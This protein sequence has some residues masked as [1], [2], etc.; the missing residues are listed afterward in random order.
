M[1]QR[2][3]IGCRVHENFWRFPA[4]GHHSLNETVETDDETIRAIYVTYGARLRKR[5]RKAHV[6]EADID[7]V[8]HDLIVSL[9][10]TLQTGGP[11][12]AALMTYLYGVARNHI[13]NYFRRARGRARTVS[14]ASSTEDGEEDLVLTATPEERL[15]EEEFQRFF[16]ARLAQMKPERRD[17]LQLRFIDELP[18]DAV[19]EALRIPER[20]AMR[21]YEAALREVRVA[22]A[23]WARERGHLRAFPF[24]LILARLLTE[25]HPGGDGALHGD[26][27]AH[28]GHPPSGLDDAAHGRGSRTLDAAESMAAPLAPRALAD[29]R[30]RVPPR[31]SI[32]EKIGKSRF[33]VYL[34]GAASGLLLALLFQHSKNVEGPPIPAPIAERCLANV[35]P[36]PPAGIKAPDVPQPRQSTPPDVQPAGPAPVPILQPT[37]REDLGK[38]EREGLDRFLVGA[39]RLAASR[40][41][42]EEARG[43][44]QRHARQFPDSPRAVE[45]EAIL[46]GLNKQGHRD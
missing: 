6:P 32:F 14:V 17:V 18:W 19:V 42:V 41:N 24:P 2:L 30:P 25:E 3:S 10:T 45:R 4:A 40:G 39:A 44:L 28:A 43:L 33:T 22:Y 21:H 31:R 35:A 15:A 11:T 1:L 16:D 36:P 20:T 34:I 27:E 29:D 38:E 7:D 37:A 13:A 23:A 46:A 12:R 9:Q 5:L 8:L 26:P